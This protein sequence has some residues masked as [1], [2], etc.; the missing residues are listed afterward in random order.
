MTT[1][2]RYKHYPDRPEAITAEFVRAE[3]ARLESRIADAEQSETPDK[4]LALHAD[5]NSL[6]ALVGG[7]GSRRNHAFS[8]DLTNPEREEADR[9]W[10]QEV[11]PVAQLGESHIVN[12]L[13]ASRHRGAIAAVHGEH[14]IRSL[15]AAV[16]PLDPINAELRVRT[17]NLATDYV[18]LLGEAEVEI[19][20]ERMTIARAGS[21]MSSPD[22]ATRE[23]ALV[24]SRE[25]ILAHRDI[26]S[27]IYDDLVKARH[28][29]A[30]NLGHENF[31]RLGYLGM[32]RV[33]YGPAE[34]EQFRANVRRYAV[35]LL[36]RMHRRQAEAL[37]LEML[38]PWDVGYDPEHTLP[39]GIVPIESQLDKAE[40]V[41][42]ALSPQLAAHFVRM[43]EQDL[44]DLENRKGKR[45]GAYC[46]SFADEG[47]VAI[48]CNSTGEQDDVR[49][50]MH[51]M[52]HAFQKWESQPIADIGLQRP[53]SDLA[54]VHSMGMEYLSM[55]HMDEYFAGDDLVKFR[56]GR[57]K[58]AVTLLCY[59]C[60]VDEFQHWVYAHPS[61][62]PDQRDVE[63]NR[64]WDTYHPG[65]DYTGVEKYK[66]ARW[67]AQSHIFAMPFYYID[68]AL[69]ETGAM[70]LGL[71]DAQDHELGLEK[72]LELC[73]IGGTDSMQRVFRAIGLRSPF[74][75]SVM[76]DLMEHAA[77]E[78]G[79]TLEAET[80][81]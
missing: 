27:G 69:A 33:D 52:G 26:L 8:R 77:G 23:E 72:Y 39:I 11:M 68:Y 16:E 32:G 9:Y 31:I 65:I 44:I 57:W 3:Y 25:W 40:R 18:K 42:S 55:R 76:H 4:W 30:R 80:A 1:T 74:D 71:I 54:E 67:Y 66:A 81:R 78:L 19:K 36:E 6:R 70:Q 15:E 17:G 47:R 7:E 38:R 50:L 79:M 60:V 14:L 22:R 45:S 63:W 13:L 35:P 75:A 61:A 24:K 29:M 10:R 59:V 46:T 2:P 12:A 43:R 21:L 28:Q 53:T 51:E 48:L 73:R 41:F 34:V 56:R 58:K 5:W 64:L 62:S 37:G 20:G 49:T